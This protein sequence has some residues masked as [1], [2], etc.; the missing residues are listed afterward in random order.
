M[1]LEKQIRRM[2]ARGC[3]KAEVARFIGVSS[4][5]LAMI[6]EHIEGL[7]WKPSKLNAVGKRPEESLP[8]LAANLV[9]AR[10]ARKASLTHTVRGVT[11]TVEELW[12]HFTPG[13]S[14]STVNR[15]VAAGMDLREAMFLPRQNKG[16]VIEKVKTKAKIKQNPGS[17]T[18]TA[19]AVIEHRA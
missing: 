3:S 18:S 14:Y 12:A 9:K 19:G 16:Q 7:V 4:P 8:R 6:C 5:K 17:R 1:D 13:V 11:G 10:A 15:R 2:A